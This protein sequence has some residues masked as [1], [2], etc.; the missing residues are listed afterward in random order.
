MTIEWVPLTVNDVDAWAGLLAAIEDVEQTGENYD[1]DDLAER[2]ANPLLDPAEG[3]LAAWDSGRLVAV[4]VVMAR[5]AAAPVHQMTLWGGVHPGHRRRG[6]GGH[7]LRWAIGTA[8]TLHERR[9]PGQPLELHLYSDV[10]NEGAQALAASVGMSQVRWFH[11]M[12]R[13]LDAD[14]P[15][16]SLPDGLKIV[17]YRDDLEDAARQVRNLSFTD[18]WG[19]VEHTAESWRAGIVG[20]KAFR[21]EGSFVVQDES[22]ASVGILVTHYFEADTA[23]TGIREAWI[24]L[25]GTLREWRGRGVATAVIAHALAEFR[26]QGY[27]RAGLGVDADNPTG[28]LGVYTRAGF[29]TGHRTV[30]YAL[31]LVP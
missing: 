29:E 4:G 9:F 12:T 28:A 8:P 7:L 1:A 3:T 2:L 15:E 27:R 19:S 22:G 14:L 21:P 10:R 23:A 18:H 25:I 30:T 24:Q 17:T 26:A 31:P 11:E 5:P 16:V 6:L 13:D 20:V